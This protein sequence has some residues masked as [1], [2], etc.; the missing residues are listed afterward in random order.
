MKKI[1]GQ[2]DISYRAEDLVDSTELGTSALIFAHEASGGESSIDLTAI[3]TPAVLSANGFTNPSPAEIAAARLLF[4]RK[5]LRL[6]SSVRGRM[7]DYDAYVVST[8]TVISFVGFTLLPGEIIKGEVSETQRTGTVLADLREFRTTYFLPAGQTVVPLGVTYRVNANSAMQGSSV[9][10]YQDGIRIVRNE[11]NA[12]ASPSANGNYQEI[13]AGSGYGNSIELNVPAGINGSVIDVDFGVFTT[14]G[15]VELFSS[16]ER[17]AGICYGMASDLALAT[18]NPVSNYMTAS[19]SEIDRATY[20]ATV[21]SNTARIAAAEVIRSTYI[22]ADSTSLKTPPS[23]GVYLAMSGNSITVPNGQ[24]WELSGTVRFVNGGLAPG[25]SYLY[26]LWA[27]SN[28]TDSSTS[29]SGTVRLAGASES[30]IGGLS[31][32]GEGIMQMP[33]IRVG[34]GTYYLVPYAAMATPANAR[35][36][37]T[38]YGRRIK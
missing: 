36:G 7:H 31:S 33:T 30:L 12:A 10:V 8:S 14:E 17:L 11:N 22:S 26:A 9:R 2:E 5:N 13:D 6:Y 35:V 18:G 24:E 23:S 1:T 32:A 21:L 34:G 28:G 4:Y 20:A 27:S 19:L 25:Y 29:P 3:T 37:T 16:L 38:I 15:S